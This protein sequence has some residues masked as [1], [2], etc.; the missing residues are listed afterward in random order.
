M[1]G[2]GPSLLPGTGSSPVSCLGLS[3][4]VSQCGLKE[5]KDRP[6][7]DCSRS[8]EERSPHQT[9]V[10]RQ[11]RGKKDGVVIEGWREASWA[12]GDRFPQARFTEWARGQGPSGPEGAGGMQGLT[13]NRW[14]GCGQKPACPPAASES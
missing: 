10:G 1:W 13:V 4:P 11:A 14:P 7:G 5:A 12:G 3:S 9:S 6:R 8:G 2:F